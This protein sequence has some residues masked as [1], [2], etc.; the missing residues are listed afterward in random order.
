[1]RSTTRRAPYANTLDWLGVRKPRKP[2]L[3]RRSRLCSDQTGNAFF[4]YR[5]D[6]LFF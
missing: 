2:A 5:S 4:F 6:Y 3:V 1:M